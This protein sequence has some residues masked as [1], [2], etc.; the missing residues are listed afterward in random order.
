MS[1]VPV[2][3]PAYS[4]G[5]A[6]D[7][8]VTLSYGLADAVTAL[9]LEETL[10]AGWTFDSITS[11]SGANINPAAGSSGT[12]QFLW[13]VVPAFPITF[14]YRVNA[15]AGATGDHTVSG[16]IIYRTTGDELRT[17]P[18]LTVLEE[19]QDP[20]LLPVAVEPQGQAY[21]GQPIVVRW[22]VTNAS[23]SPAPATWQEC[24]YLSMDDQ[25]G[26]DLLL[27]CVTRERDAGPGETYEVR[28]EF[29]LPAVDVGE[30]W[31][32][33]VTDDGDAVA[34]SNEDD[35]VIVSAPITI[36]TVN[37]AATVTTSVTKAAAGTTV[38]LTGEAHFLASGAPAPNVPVAVDVEVRGIHRVFTVQT[39][40]S[41]QFSLTFTPL[42]A[43]A[44]AYTVGAK[45]PGIVVTPIQDTFTLAGLALDRPVAAF[46]LAPGI[47]VEAVFELRNLGDTPLT[48]LSASVAGS[49]ANVTVHAEVD[50][51]LP[52]LG[53]GTVMVT[54]DALNDS[55]T[56]GQATLTVSTS[57]GATVA[58]EIQFRVLPAA[59]D[60]Q[61]AHVPLRAGAAAG[62]QTLYSFQLTNAGGATAA[63]LTVS[64]PASLPWVHVVAPSRP[65]DLFPGESVEV[66]VQCLAPAGQPTGVVSGQ[67]T[68]LFNEGQSRVMTLQIRV[69]ATD[70]GDLYVWVKDDFGAVADAAV[71]LRDPFT[72]GETATQTTSATGSAFFEGIAGGPYNFEVRTPDHGDYY[73]ATEVRRGAA[74]HE[75]V[76][77]H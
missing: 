61:A 23:N 69:S 77:L 57:E 67:L 76:R 62:A 40:G 42:A 31:V 16:V 1:R 29:P 9:A 6:V 12:L 2:G 51:D 26:D 15:P 64:P 66:T 4:P 56:T 46:D 37:Y 10:P 53:S 71:V 21:A 38:P 17:D 7:L 48:G 34:E 28:A 41:G 33:V 72:G 30:Y 32:I 43:E 49:P 13:V 54:L 3:G 47:P 39:N 65:V 35:N 70:A 52:P 11:G 25:P 20:N 60:L 5:A 75:E 50:P 68:F 27:G 19:A 45:H 14:T 74:R 22:I 63:G 24:A 73:G 36:E 8:T 58:Q 44:G 59:V 55:V 18:V